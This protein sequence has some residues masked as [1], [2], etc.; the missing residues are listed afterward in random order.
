MASNLSFDSFGFL[1]GPNLVGAKGFL[2]SQD[3][4]LG[5]AFGTST[6]TYAHPMHTHNWY[7][8]QPPVQP[9]AAPLHA[10]L[11]APQQPNPPQSKGNYVGQFRIK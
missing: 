6:P 4:Y 5:S 9:H 8:G 3:V 2:K 11:L 10:P 7:T 1:F